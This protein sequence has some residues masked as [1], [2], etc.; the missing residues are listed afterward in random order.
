MT[1]AQKPFSWQSYSPQPVN[2]GQ[3]L[4]DTEA[5]ASDVADGQSTNRLNRSSKVS[6][7]LHAGT[8]LMLAN[9]HANFHIILITRIA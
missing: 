6:S 4:E 2:F 9:A 1:S 8:D 3:K 5:E 7:R